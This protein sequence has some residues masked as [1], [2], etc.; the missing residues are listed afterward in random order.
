MPLN[1]I[2]QVQVDELLT[3]ANLA[4]SL[5]R[6]THEPVQEE[7]TKPMADE[8]EIEAG[9][10][11]Q[12]MQTY[13][14]GQNKGNRTVLTCPECGGVIWELQE[15]ELIRFRCHVGHAYS[16]DSLLLEQGEALE[17]AL[18][19]AVR[20]LEERAALLGRLAAQAAE[21]DSQHTASRFREQS[22][23]AERQADVIRRVLLNG[24]AI[25]M[26]NTEDIQAME[27]TGEPPSLASPDD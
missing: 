16:A 12:D 24:K 15:G 14:Q 2:K 27:E 4:R 8:N 25:G 3:L 13:A 7:G 20:A 23:A 9:L 22:Q 26:E 21:R 17:A 19:T 10:V 18:W 5:D 11:E 1:T 6:L